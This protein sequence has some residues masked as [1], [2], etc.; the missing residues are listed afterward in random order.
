MSFLYIIL[1]AVIVYLAVKWAGKGKQQKSSQ[2]G[3][4]S[5]KAKSDFPPKTT[6]PAGGTKYGKWVGGGLGWAFGGPIGGILGFVFGSIYDGMKSGQAGYQGTRAGD[7]SVSLL[8]LTASVMKADGKVVKSEL[9]YV[10]AF[11]VR[12]FGEQQAQEKLLLLKEIIKQDVNLSE[13]CGQ[14]SQ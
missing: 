3:E 9:E 5:K 12:Q 1:I 8:I 13:V 6:P 4:F 14:I 10:K 2:Q 11:L 7:F